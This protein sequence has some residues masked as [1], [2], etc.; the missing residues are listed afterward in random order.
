M[1]ISP[2]NEKFFECNKSRFE[3][4]HGVKRGLIDNVLL[5]GYKNRLGW[6]FRY[7]TDEEINK[8]N[9]N[10]KLLSVKCNDYLLA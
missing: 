8:Y 10:N 6:K 2:E 7:L 1:A 9:L 4:E 5:H 3:R